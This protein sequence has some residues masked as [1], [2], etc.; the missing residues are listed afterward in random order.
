MS[1]PLVVVDVQPS[2][3]GAWP[4]LRPLMARASEHEGPLL[5]LVNAEDAGTTT[6]TVDGCREFWLEY[7]LDE[8]VLDRARVVDKGYGYLRAW[9]DLGA[10][11]EV[12][13]AALRLMLER[14]VRDSRDLDPDE[15][16]EAVGDDW[17]SYMAD[18]PLSLGW[19][20]DRTLGLMHGALICGG[21]RSECL[22]E[23]EILLRA[24]RIDYEILD[25]FVYDGLEAAPS[26]ARPRW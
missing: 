11:E 25:E 26:P 5:L 13:V 15:L 8:E 24:H 14:G 2:Y 1:R 23:V 6:D 18:E 3:C 12:I 4:R 10:D 22:R 19:I 21:A 20:D 17:Q 9:M 7:G 16:R